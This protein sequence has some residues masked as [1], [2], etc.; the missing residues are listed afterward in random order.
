[1]EYELTS[2]GRELEPAL[3]E[4]KRWARRWLREETRTPVT[5]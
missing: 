4:L 2:M 5:R 3:S 1:V